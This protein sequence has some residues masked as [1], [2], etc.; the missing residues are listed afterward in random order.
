MFQVIHELNSY[1]R[2]WV[3]YFG[4]HEFK[5][6]FRDLDAWIRS[7]LRSMQLKKWEKLRRLQRIMANAICKNHMHKIEE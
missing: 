3:N 1:L 5:Y 4:I 2:G 7:R 6:L